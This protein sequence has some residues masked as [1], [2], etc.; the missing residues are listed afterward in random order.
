LDDAFPNIRTLC[1]ENASE[2]IAASDKLLEGNAHPHISYHLSLLALEEI[3]KGCMV[4]ARSTVGT[5][6]DSGWMDKWLSNH[7]RKLQLAIWSPINRIDPNDFEEARKF[8]ENVHARRLASLYVDAD[9]D[10]ADIRARNNV[11]IEDATSMLAPARS[12]LAL[13]E[14]SGGPS[15]DVDDTLKWY[16]D[17]QKAKELDPSSEGVATAIV[18]FH[19]DQAKYEAAVTAADEAL[20]LLEDKTALEVMRAEALARGGKGDDALASLNKIII[21]KPGNANLLNGRCWVR[22]ILDR[23]LELALKDCTKAI[24]LADSLAAILDSRSLV[25]FRLKRYNDAIADLDAALLINSALAQSRY[26]RGVSHSWAGQSLE[27]KTDI[28][29]ARLINP[30]IDKNYSSIGVSPKP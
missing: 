9:A 29:D 21:G 20:P 27:A 1:L 6:R 24:E 3:G 14:A 2:L 17:L 22:G 4:A 8:A 16:S 19:I 23:E 10:I 26:L 15:G 13:E 28:A 18:Q 7:R 11:T 5:S 12:R 25:Y 30:K